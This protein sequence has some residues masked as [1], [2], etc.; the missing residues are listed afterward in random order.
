MEILDRINDYYFTEFFVDYFNNLIRLGEIGVNRCYNNNDY[1]GM[2]KSNAMDIADQEIL[3]IDINVLLSSNSFMDW[4]N[5]S[6]KY[7][8]LY[9]S[10]Y[11]YLHKK[12]INM[13]N[14]VLNWFKEYYGRQIINVYELKDK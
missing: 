14:L 4:F 10:I 9:H 1:I 5:T 8:V 13:Q 3:K 2:S 12:N 6:C 11:I 7:T